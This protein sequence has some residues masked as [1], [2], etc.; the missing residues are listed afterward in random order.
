MEEAK[1]GERRSKGREGGRER[2]RERKNSERQDNSRKRVVIMW[3]VMEAECT[4]PY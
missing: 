2:E 4:K 1:D 3:G